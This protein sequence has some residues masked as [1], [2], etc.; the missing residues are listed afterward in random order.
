MTNDINVDLLKIKAELAEN[1][2]RYAANS[3]AFKIKTHEKNNA[4]SR[5]ESDGK[6][7]I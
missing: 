6:L 7:G 5:R 2:K 3:Y 1:V 4:P